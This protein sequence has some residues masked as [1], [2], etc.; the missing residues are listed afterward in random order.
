LP[1][2]ARDFN[3][4]NVIGLWCFA[5]LFFVVLSGVVISYPW[6]GNL[7][8]RVV[9]SQPPP[10]RTA[11]GPAATAAPP[12]DLNL[13]GIGEHLRDA[14]DQVMGWKAITLR[15]PGSSGAPLAF[16]VDQGSAGQPQKRGTLLVNRT[17]G[18]QRWETFASQDAG[19]RLRSW[20]RFVHTGE[21]YG[22]PGQTIA[23]AASLGG[24]F[25]VYTGLAL[26]LRRF[27]GWR[28]RRSRSEERALVER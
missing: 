6:A 12:L 17:T 25:L 1:G 22:L 4:H 7:V 9:G 19:R 24:V 21:Y 27:A 11:S 28:A 5:P 20:L 15:L 26:A 14:E 13:S 16:T 10:L 18:E 8:Y 3:W 2:K 23:G